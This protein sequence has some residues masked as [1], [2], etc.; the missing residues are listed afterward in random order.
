MIVKNPT[1]KTVKERY[2]IWHQ[3]GVAE[4]EVLQQTLHGMCFVA[5][6]WLI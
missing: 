6:W 2:E 5:G 3:A 4:L 1:N